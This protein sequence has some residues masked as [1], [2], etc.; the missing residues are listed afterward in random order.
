MTTIP[1]VPQKRNPWQISNADL[2][3]LMAHGGMRYADISLTP[4]R[5]LTALLHYIRQTGPFRPRA[6]PS[7]LDTPMTPAEI[8][9]LVQ[10]ANRNRRPR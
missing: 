10:M 6:R 8:Q 1:F 3:Q 4:P 2:V 5:V 7:P 9:N